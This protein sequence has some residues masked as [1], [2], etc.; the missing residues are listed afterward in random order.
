MQF[1]G[2]FD[3]S[4]STQDKG[5]SD[6][7]ANIQQTAP[8]LHDLLKELMKPYNTGT[9]PEKEQEDVSRPFNISCLLR[10]NLFGRKNDQRDGLSSKR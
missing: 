3:A 1:F 9:D 10:T 4:T 2:E 8:Q 6:M 7:M 5:L